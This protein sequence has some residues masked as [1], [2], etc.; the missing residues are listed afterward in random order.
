MVKIINFLRSIY[1]LPS[2][3][4]LAIKE[5]EDA[6]RKLLEMESTFDYA[7]SMCSYYKIKINR[8]SLYIRKEG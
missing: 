8:L 4:V 1:L 5:L 2:A 6:K 3:R 7:Q